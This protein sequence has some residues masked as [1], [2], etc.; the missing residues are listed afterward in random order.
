[1]INARLMSIHYLNNKGGQTDVVYMLPEMHHM[2]K[3]KEV[4]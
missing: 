4:A 2:Q 1:M 3:G